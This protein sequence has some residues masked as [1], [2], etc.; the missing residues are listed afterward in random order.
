MYNTLPK[1]I[2]KK[3]SSLCGFSIM[4]PDG[5]GVNESK[6]INYS[7]EPDIWLIGN[8][9]NVVLDPSMQTAVHP[10]PPP[11]PPGKNGASYCTQKVINFMI[12][13]PHN[14]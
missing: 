12:P 4:F 5:N 14:Y 6:S 3:I 10:P 11:P 1:G 9:R 7:V 2:H 8:R 13:L